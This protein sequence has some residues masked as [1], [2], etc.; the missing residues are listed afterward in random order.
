MARRRRRWRTASPMSARIASSTASSRRSSVSENIGLGWL[1]KFGRRRLIAPLAQDA[2]PGARV[3]RAP[4]DPTA[5]ADQPA[6]HLSGGNQQK[7]VIAKSLAQKPRLVIFD[8]PTR[9]VDVG[10]VAEIHQ[11]IRDLAACWGRRGG[12]LVLPA[13]NPRRVRSHPGRQERHDRRRVFASGG[14]PGEDSAGG[15]PLRKALGR[16]Y[17]SSLSAAPHSERR[18]SKSSPA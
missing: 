1:A 5:G 6:L 17:C 18:R 13:G 8:E 12:D 10:A 11:I 15:D 7:V 4:V 14:E 9:G 2:E 16:E 3:G